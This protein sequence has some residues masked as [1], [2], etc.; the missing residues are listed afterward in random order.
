MIPSPAVHRAGPAATLEAKPT[1]QTQAKAATK[2]GDPLADAYYQFILGCHL[3]DSGDVDGA[4]VAFRRAMALDPASADIPAAL[5]GLYARQRRARDAIDAAKSALAINPGHAGAHLVMGSIFAGLAER[6]PDGTAAGGGTAGNR[7]LAIEHLEQARKVSDP[8]AAAGVRLTLGRLYLQASA[9]DKAIVVLKQLLADEP[10]LPQGVALLAQAYTEAGRG[11][12]AID[13]LKEAVTVEPSF[14]E[15]LASAYEKNNQ[16]ADAAAA[17]EHASI[18]S[19]NDTDIKTRWA[20]AL[21]S[22]PGDASARRAR[23][24]LEEVT[25]ANPTSGWP[26]YL[27]ARAQRAL[28]DLDASEASARRLM[29]ISPGSTSGAHAL[30]Q[31]LE[32]RREWPALIEALEPVAAKPPKGR[33]ADTALILTHLGFAYL[34][35]GRAA[36]AVAAFDRASK[37]DPSSDSA[38]AYLAQALVAAKEYDRALA[39]VRTALAADPADTR[40]ARIEA[41]ALRGMGRFDDGAAILKALAAAS[42]RDPGAVRTLAEYYAEAHRYGEAAELLKDAVAGFPGDTALLFQ[43]GAMLE[44]QSRHNDAERVFRQI[45][46]ADPAHGPTLNYLGYTLVERGGNRLPEA[47]ELLKRAVALDPYNGAYLDS[48]GWAYFKLSQLDLA[49]P[50]LKAA[51]AQLPVDSVVQDHWGDFLAKRGRYAD[52]VEAWRRALAGDGEQ[53]DRG[54]VER[55]IRDALNK[56]GRN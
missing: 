18:Q 40:L 31:V 27:L 30:A 9:F 34:E 23:S 45:L 41:G 46:A 36:D 38:T 47:V 35:V 3:E 44:R 55:K 24:L 13:L 51:A 15:A 28:G 26:L 22:V 50:N 12:S 39:L 17:F 19:P 56:S 43:Y 48:L 20:F 2:A 53:I 32:A 33:D 4:V 1:T 54:H 49:E 11:E 21:L 10:W 52:A 29:A 7:Q 6:D 37:L 14:Y 8:G 25:K 16:W 42:P 5:A